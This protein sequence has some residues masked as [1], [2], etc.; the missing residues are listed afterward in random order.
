MWK[1]GVCDECG[2]ETQV[3]RSRGRWLCKECFKEAKKKRK[4]EKLR[5]EGR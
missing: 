2:A 1:K 5:L 3:R 4:L